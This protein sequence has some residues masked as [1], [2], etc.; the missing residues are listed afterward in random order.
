MAKI[1]I[2]SG[3]RD[4]LEA[5]LEEAKSRYMDLYPAP[6][7]RCQKDGEDPRVSGDVFTEEEIDKNA[8]CINAF[9]V[10]SPIGDEAVLFSTFRAII[11][12]GIEFAK[13]NKIKSIVIPSCLLHALGFSGSVMSLR[14]AV[15]TISELG[16]S[17]KDITITITPDII[18]DDMHVL[19]SIGL[20]YLAGDDDEDDDRIDKLCKKASRNKK[21]GKK[22]G[23]KKG[24]KKK[25]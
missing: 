20:T 9:G 19:E 10:F 14:T 15:A 2:C 13:T 25:K 4:A 6:D 16:A 5:S 22:G 17:A 23:K 12:N 8:V 18:D 3:K 1:L 7:S 11:A 24:K 21:K